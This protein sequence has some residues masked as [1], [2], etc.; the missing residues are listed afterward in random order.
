MRKKRSTEAPAF[1]TGGLPS[2]YGDLGDGGVRHSF[3]QP[4]GSSGGAPATGGPNKSVASPNSDLAFLGRL[5]NLSGGIGRFTALAG[6]GPGAITNLNTFSFSKGSPFQSE[7]GQTG[8]GMSTSPAGFQTGQPLAKRA[9]LETG[10][11]SVSPASISAASLSPANP[12]AGLQL[13]AKREAPQFIKGLNSLDLFLSFVEEYSDGSGRVV[14]DTSQILSR[15]CYDAWIKTRRNVLK[16][17][18]ESFRRALT[19]H[20]TGADR[21]RPF[22]ENVEKSLLTELRKQQTWACFAGRQST[23]GRDCKIGEQGFR[24]M[25][26]H[27]KKAYDAA[28]AETRAAMEVP[29]YH[30]TNPPAPG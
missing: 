12:T 8:L 27:E 16:K 25:G 15:A 28:D 30:P 14:I 9:K 18:E 10:A 19:A 6:L 22:P 20:V 29:I 23:D 11:G 26:Y 13:R 17:P 5:S 21:R 2:S 24:T 7:L 1:T 4:I 3:S